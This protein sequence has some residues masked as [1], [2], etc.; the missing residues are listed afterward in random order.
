MEMMTFFDWAFV[1][2]FAGALAVVSLI[3]Q[4][5]KGWAFLAKV[6][7]QILTWALGFVVL[8]LADVFGGTLTVEKAVLDVIN[9]GLVGLAA[10][11]GYAAVKRIMEPKDGTDTPSGDL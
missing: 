2:T 7:T 8:I 4:L 5:V 10:N 1:G 3:T 6:P 9:G 11:G